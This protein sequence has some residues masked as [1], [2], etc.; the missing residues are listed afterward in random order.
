MHVHHWWRSA[1]VTEVIIDD[2]ERAELLSLSLQVMPLD[3]M[4]GPLDVG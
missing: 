4:S 3:K 2:V 1:I